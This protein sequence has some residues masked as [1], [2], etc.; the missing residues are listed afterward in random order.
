MGRPR[1][2]PLPQEVHDLKARIDA[3]RSNRRGREHMPREF[4]T[5]AIELSKVHGVCRIARSVGL[6]YKGLRRKIAL[7]QRR[8]SPPQQRFVEVPAQVV[9]APKGA[10]AGASCP[11]PPSPPTPRTTVE[12]TAPDGA[13]LRIHAPVATA[14]ELAGL[15]TAFL[16]RDR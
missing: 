10:L 14:A 6:D 2:A 1:G 4:W 5:D 15:V 7:F 16:G 12:V 13:Q 3:W 8:A 11:P 9:L